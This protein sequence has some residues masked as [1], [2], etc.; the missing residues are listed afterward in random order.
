MEKYSESS[1]I[2]L[3][4]KALLLPSGH[5]FQIHTPSRSRFSRARACL[6]SNLHHATFRLCSVVR[7]VLLHLL[8]IYLFN[9][10]SIVN[11]TPYLFFQAILIYAISQRLHMQITARVE[12]YLTLPLE[13]ATEFERN[14]LKIFSISIRSSHS[15]SATT[16]PCNL[17]FFSFASASCDTMCSPTRRI[18]FQVDIFGSITAQ[19]TVWL[20]Q[21][22]EKIWR[23]S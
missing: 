2:D 12:T 9:Y 1:A 11:S 7:I 6:V 14:Y 3:A 20:C 15:S 17:P 22:R 5:A 16:S 13:H 4:E 21:L 18:V 23:S 8:K 19:M 10:V